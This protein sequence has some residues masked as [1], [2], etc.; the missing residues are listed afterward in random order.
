MSAFIDFLTTQKDFY[1]PAQVTQKREFGLLFVK[2]PLSLPVTDSTVL[3]S[4]FSIK[5]NNTLA[6]GDYVKIKLKE[7]PCHR[8]KRQDDLETYHP[9]P[10]ATLQKAIDTAEYDEQITKLNNIRTAF[11]D[12]NGENLQSLKELFSE[13]YNWFCFKSTDFYLNFEKLNS[14]LRKL[15]ETTQI[16]IAELDAYK[17][18]NEAANQ[19][20]KKYRLLSEELKKEQAE[21][22]EKSE[23]LTR[24]QEKIEEEQEL[25]RLEKAHIHHDITELKAFGLY[26]EVPSKE[27]K[28]TP[29][30]FNSEKFRQA[31]A[32]P[33]SPLI[34][35]AF[36]LALVS[37]LIRGRLILLEGSVGVGKTYLAE[38]FAK[39]LGGSSK[40]I[41]VR[42]SWID[43]SDLFGFFDPLSRIFRPASF[44]EAIYDAPKDR[45]Y[46]I[47]LDEMNLSRIENYGADLLSR[48]EKIAE[49]RLIDEQQ[50]QAD[51]LQIWSSDECTSLIDELETITKLP[52]YT[53]KP[54][55]IQRINQVIYS[56]QK[57]TPRMPL[58]DGFILMGTLNADES[59]YEVSPKVIDRSYVLSFPNLSISHFHT[60]TNKTDTFNLSIN[61]FRKKFRP[62]AKN[63]DKTNWLELNK[64]IS[65]EE[66]TEIGIPYSYRLMTDYADMRNFCEI[67]GYQEKE[68]KE[69]FIW[70]RILPRISFFKA[71]NEQNSKTQKRVLDKLLNNSSDK[72]LKKYF[73]NQMDDDNRTLVKFFGR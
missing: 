12:P 28:N 11:D 60:S 35:K 59:T 23:L 63:A 42:P 52:N 70:S 8:D 48:I 65:D 4:E 13:T 36:Q 61:E 34:E 67:M 2:I 31:L 64:I 18:K 27:T 58:P 41:P 1:L 57:Y 62:A 32:Y 49:S 69:A 72:Y 50:N 33:Q 20:V 53:Q 40:T 9:R 51:M 14:I 44:T 16:A 43:S 30:P 7:V 73:E 71:P 21:F 17:L 22:K 10:K 39:Q 56:L 55:Y 19:A 5:G 54:E 38:N 68:Y 46:P 45:I 3:V 26:K 29:E 37:S 25:I 47:I 15:E 6:V 24:E 66:M